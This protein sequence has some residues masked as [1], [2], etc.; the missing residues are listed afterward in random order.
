[1]SIRKTRP[2]PD[3]NGLGEAAAASKRSEG[4][5]LTYD[6]TL[7]TP[8][9]GGGVQAGVVDQTM[10]IRATAIRGQLRFWWRLLNRKRFANTHDMFKAERAIWGGLGDE[11]TLAKSKVR[12]SATSNGSQ[13]R[14]LQRAATY[15]QRDGKWRGPDF[16]NYPGYALFP[17]QG[18][19]E[20]GQITEEPKLLLKEGM[21]FKL[22]LHLDPGL[23][24]DQQAQILAALHWW[25]SFGGVGARTRRGCGAVQ[26]LDAKKQFIGV[27]EQDAAAQGWRLVLSGFS[28]NA[29]EVWEKAIEHLRDFRQKPGIARNLGQ[30]PRPGRSRWPEPDAIR[31]ITGDAAEEHQPAHPAGNAFPRAA[32]GLPIIT[33]FKQEREWRR[34]DPQDTT[35]KP[36]PNNSEKPTERMASPLIL[37]PYY[38][39][40]GW[41]PAALCLG[42]DHIRT[43]GLSLE[44]KFRGS[45]H[46]IKAG[47]W[48]AGSR[49]EQIEPMRGRGEDA[50]E[51]FLAYFGEQKGP[52]GTAKGKPA[53]LAAQARPTGAVGVA[54][55][56]L[57]LNLKNGSLEAKHIK[58]N[59]SYYA[60]GAEVEPL[61]SSLPDAIQEDL[62]GGRYVFCDIEVAGYDLIAVR[63][64]A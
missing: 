36:I 64:K 14:G 54:N 29:V 25:A 55:V 31:R 30:G 57:Q 51:A 33:H 62:R 11:T 28:G 5:T 63:E 17:G 22:T 43:M 60:R 12:V 3:S 46:V 1:M 24:S 34:L 23:D 45:P 35:L 26:V 7:V 44:G 4:D 16:G 38:D 52:A 50:I 27:G 13:P 61:I 9:Y 41:R 10:P 2:A 47:Q 8:M 37:R 6:C 58:S 19:S 48:Q 21:A 18:K 59:K 20:R 15:T 32:F 53:A 40:K 49:A 39:G 42:L 56:K